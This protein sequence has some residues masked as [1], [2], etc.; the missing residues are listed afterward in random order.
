[1]GDATCR[2]L[3]DERFI[4]TS[5]PCLGIECDVRQRSIWEIRRLMTYFLKSRHD[6]IP[7]DLSFG[8]DY[9]QSNDTSWRA[10]IVNINHCSKILN[11]LRLC[12]SQGDN[13]V[14]IRVIAV[15]L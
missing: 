14:A 12:G 6:R 1:M 9:R 13:F 15:H 10:R 3:A 2:G 5:M 4:S 11:F 7:E 8:V